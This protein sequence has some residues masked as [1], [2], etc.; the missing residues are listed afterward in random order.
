[1]KIRLVV[2]SYR[3]VYA[4]SLDAYVIM[5]CLGNLSPLSPQTP[6]FEGDLQL[7]FIEQHVTTYVLI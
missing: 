3:Y 2:T 1:M 6:G 5:T 4:I 7:S